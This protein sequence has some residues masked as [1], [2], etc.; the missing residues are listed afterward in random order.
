M[1]L[2]KK[3]QVIAAHLYQ[4]C[5]AVDDG[6]RLSRTGELVPSTNCRVRDTR[7][8]F[9]W[10][11]EISDE[12]PRFFTK[13]AVRGAIDLLL[14]DSDYPMSLPQSPGYSL[15]AWADAQTDVVHKTLRKFRKQNPG[16]HA[17]G[18]GASTPAA[19]DNMETQAYDQ[20]WTRVCFPWGLA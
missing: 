16:C 10:V 4:S 6:A 13:A 17:T 18:L 11:K 7:L 19:M 2:E 1:D 5:V 15:S 9:E 12:T 14:Q 20:D 8:A 3:S